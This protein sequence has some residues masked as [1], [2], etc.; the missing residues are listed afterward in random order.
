MDTHISL[1]YFFFFSFF[2]GKNCVPVREGMN[3]LNFL[4]IKDVVMVREVKM[5][6]EAKAQLLAPLSAL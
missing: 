4:Q 3:F 2:L 1:G 5:N 6:W